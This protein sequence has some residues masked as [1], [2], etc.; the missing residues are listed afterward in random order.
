MT[1]VIERQCTL[2]DILRLRAETQPNQRAYTFLVDGER[3]EVHLTYGELDQ[4]VQS[5]ADRLQD[6]TYVGDRALL[7]YPPGL[8]FIKAF[9]GC[10][11]AGIV[12]V[13][14]YPPRRNRENVRL[15]AIAQDAQPQVIVAHASFQTLRNKSDSFPLTTLR[16][17]IIAEDEPSIAGW[18][19][20][21]DHCNR[22]TSLLAV[23][24]RLDQ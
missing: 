12:A 2:V 4:A 20:G 1:P 7:L 17:L 10:L 13:P 21:T 18:V 3:E 23:H 6:V 14:T 16:W 24:L 22:Y 15:Q 8:E 5:I 9:Y 19:A 11:Y